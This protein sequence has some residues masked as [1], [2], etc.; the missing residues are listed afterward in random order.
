M[1][2]NA[3]LLPERF[4]RPAERRAHRD[5]TGAVAAGPHPCSRGQGRRPCVP[6]ARCSGRGPSPAAEA[7][8]RQRPRIGTADRSIGRQGGWRHQP[9]PSQKTATPLIR[10]SNV[11]AEQAGQPNHARTMRGRPV[12]GLSR[13]L[14]AWFHPS[15]ASQLRTQLAGVA[16]Q[17]TRDAG[18]LCAIGLRP[19]SPRSCRRRSSRHRCPS[20]ASERDA[21]RRRSHLTRTRV[22]PRWRVAGRGRGWR[23]GRRRRAVA[24]DGSPAAAG[25]GR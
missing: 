17:V 7:A 5:T 18:R 21:G 16:A 2:S 22:A 10:R 19:A 12:P 4:G 11:L 20:S 3:A 13:K 6:T 9:V 14:W 15:C 25:S 23:S 24:A 8:L 1:R